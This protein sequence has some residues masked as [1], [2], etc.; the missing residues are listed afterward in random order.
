VKFEAYDAVVAAGLREAQFHMRAVTRSSQ[1]A[2]ATTHARAAAL[3]LDRALAG[4][5]KAASSQL[6]L[7]YSAVRG[8]SDD[9]RAMS[10]HAAVPTRPD[11]RLDLW[12]VRSSARDLAGELEIVLPRVPRTWQSAS[13]ARMARL[14]PAESRRRY[15]EE[16]L[17]ELDEIP[18]RARPSYL[19]RLALS[20]LLMRLH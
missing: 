4:R 5:R 15:V 20:F 14:L 6:L 8:L 13:V 10:R 11:P 1:L 18:A 19:A 9:L 12:Q 16:C 17:A 2:S 7:T 3:S